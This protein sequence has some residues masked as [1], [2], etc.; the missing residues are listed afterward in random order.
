MT[1]TT[2]LTRIIRNIT[3][4]ITKPT[5]AIPSHKIHVEQRI[6]LFAIAG[7][8]SAACHL[9]ELALSFACERVGQ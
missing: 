8:G 7:V 4:L 2:P 1:P 5:I 3:T 9:C 6:P